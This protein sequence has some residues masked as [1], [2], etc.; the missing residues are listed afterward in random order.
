M[1]FNDQNNEHAYGHLII[2]KIIIIMLFIIIIIFKNETIGSEIL[3][4][5]EEISNILSVALLHGNHRVSANYK[6][7]GINLG[8]LLVIIYVTYIKEFPHFYH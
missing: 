2:I 6:F 8:E 3:Y 7:N 5:I 4:D 1:D